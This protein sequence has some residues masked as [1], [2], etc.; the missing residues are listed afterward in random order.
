[1]RSKAWVSVGAG[2]RARGAALLGCQRMGR[3]RRIALADEARTAE[4]LANL[5][6]LRI[7]QAVHLLQ[8]VQQRLVLLLQRGP[9]KGRRSGHAD[10]REQ[11]T[12][13]VIHRRSFRA[14]R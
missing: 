8:L 11:E 13:P 2:R 14:S 4:D 3:D 6:H 10:C 5:L 9:G 7:A 12:N 1:M